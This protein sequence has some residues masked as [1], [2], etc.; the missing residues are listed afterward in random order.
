MSDSDA[1]R[2]MMEEHIET[3][4]AFKATELRDMVIEHTE[5]VKAVP[6][7]KVLLERVVEA[8]DGK[9]EFDLHGKQIGRVGGM[10]AKQNLIE[11]DVAALKYA[12]NGGRG[13]SV[14]TRDKV[15][16]GFIAAIPSIAILIAAI[17]SGST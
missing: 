13:F 12:G 15:I 5:L 9:P 1:A 16:I 7:T 2:E 14:R 8:L 4:H 6:E 3:Y 10:V 11:R 17:L